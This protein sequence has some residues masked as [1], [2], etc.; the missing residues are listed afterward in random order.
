MYVERK[1]DPAPRHGGFSTATGVF[2]SGEP[3]NPVIVDNQGFVLLGAWLQLLALLVTLVV[4]VV[5]R[6]P[7]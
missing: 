3:G 4:V 7:R 1:H 2:L 5:K 6:R